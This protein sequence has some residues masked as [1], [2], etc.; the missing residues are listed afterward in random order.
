M[1]P[2][3]FTDMSASALAAEIRQGRA[4]A[5][6]VVEAHIDVFRQVN[7]G[8]NALVAER[9]DAAREEARRA[10]ARVAVAA[11]DE[12][13]PPLLGVPCT[14]KEAVAFTGMPNSSGVVARGGVPATA[15]APV[16]QRLVDAGA[17]VLGVTNTS[18]MCLWVE[19]ENRLYG[20]TRNP[21]NP[22]RT[23]GGSSGGE[24]AAVGSGASPFG[25][26]SDIGGSIRI[27]SFCCGVFGHKPTRGL[28]P[29]T[30]SW[31][32]CD[33]GNRA[34]FAHGP[35]ARR[36][37]DLMPLLRIMAGPDG[38]DP[39]AA[40]MD[41]GD[42][43]DVSLRDL[44]VLLIDEAWPLAASVDML[45]A[46]ERA[47]GA[48]AAAGAQVRRRR[49]PALRRAVESY[50]TTLARMSGI[51][52]RDV[53]FAAGANEVHWRA[54]LRRGGPHT[55]AT[56]LLLVAERAQTRLPRRWAERLITTGEAIA[57]ELR[58]A[59]GDGV[60][61]EPT[62]ATTAPR[63]GRTVGRPWWLAHVVP[64]NLAGLPVTQ[65]PLGLDPEGLPL[66]VQVVAGH[67]R[68]HV[69]IAVAL[70]LERVFGGWTPPPLHVGGRPDRLVRVLS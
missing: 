9:F 50:I 17:I 35:I 64:F 42:P 29:A 36:A 2:L 13:L 22:T 26:A 30:G 47:A 23:A 44:P 56:R 4:S 25:V 53:L 48:L 18:E 68:D 61:L 41:L 31:P 39:L 52:A 5:A 55:V 33:D 40:E 51:G 28:L 20:R 27:P 38:V 59:I 14:V 49:M 21:Y 24:G 12:P 70:E 32:P 66:G 60:L 3:P 63:H 58:N 19:S 69:S 54:L 45:W 1:S 37:E 65:T 7:P 57:D 11:P 8:L 15:T 67:G 46:R 34:L 16:A 10:D 6:E 43:A 62:L